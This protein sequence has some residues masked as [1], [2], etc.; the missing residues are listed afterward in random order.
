MH[1]YVSRKSKT[2]GLEDV[3]IGFHNVE[4]SL[5]RAKNKSTIPLKT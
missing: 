3:I 5:L 1:P 4:K 2:V